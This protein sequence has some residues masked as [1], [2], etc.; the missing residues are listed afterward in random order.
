M[1]PLE[2]GNTA[3]PEAAMVTVVAFRSADG[4]VIVNENAYCVPAS[5]V[6]AVWTVSVKVPELNAP[7]ACVE[8]FPNR[9]APLFSTLVSARLATSAAFVSP[10]IVTTELCVA[11]AKLTLL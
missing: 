4:L 7:V 2:V 8:P 1:A 5:T 11:C 9:L 6:W 10:E 3:V